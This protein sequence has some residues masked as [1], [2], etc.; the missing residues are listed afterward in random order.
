MT[1]METIHDPRTLEEAEAL[2]K[3]LGAGVCPS[4]DEWPIRKTERRSA[5]LGRQST[6]FRSAGRL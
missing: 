1:R 2:L 5:G 3:Q 6:N 4:R